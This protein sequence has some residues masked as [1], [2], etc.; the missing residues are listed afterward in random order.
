VEFRVLGALEVVHD[1]K[2]VPLGGRRQ[3][4]LLAILLLRAN[5]VVSN[6]ALIDELWGERPPATAHHTLQAYVSRLRKLL[7]ENGGDENVLVS[8]PSGYLLRI[9]FGA[10]DLD[11]FEH[12][13]E[14]G[15]RALAAGAAAEA[16]EA[17]RAALS[18]WTG[19]ALADLRFEPFARV[20]VERF[21][22]R[23]L[24]V[25]EDRIEA[26]LHR[27]QHV[28]LV[29]ELEALVAEHP[30]RERL[31]EQLMLALY[32][33]GRQ[34]EA[35]EA[36]RSA[37]TYLVEECG[38]EP[39]KQLQTLHQA[40][41]DQDAQLDLDISER[42]AVLTTVRPAEEATQPR[43]EG[44]WPDPPLRDATR[45]ARRLDKSR[46]VTVG[47]AVLAVAVAVGALVV[48]RRGTDRTLRGSAVHPDSVVFIDPAHDK[49]VGQTS[50]GGR[51][52]A[53]AAGF[54]RL[55]VADGANGR[56]LVLDPS[57]FRIED[58][59]PLGREPAALVASGN[60]MWVTDPASGTVSEIAS[61]S[62]TV[63]ATVQVG[64]S[65][66]AIAAGAGALWVADA[67]SG[68]LAR[69]DP[70]TASV[71]DTI[72]V[73]QPLT[74]VTLGLGSVWVTSASSGLLFAIDPHGDRV[75]QAVS[76]GNG[77]SAVRVLGPTVWVANPPDDTLS[78]FDP[79]SGRIRKINASDPAA[80]TV[81]DGALWV[82]DR[83]HAALT[84][85]DPAT[86][87]GVRI[88]TLANPPTAMADVDGKLALITGV[89][90]AEHAGGTLRVVAGDGVDS[91]DPGAAYSATDWQLLSMT[92]DGLLTYAR[93]PQ[94]G[95]GALVPDLATSLPVVTGDGRTFTFTLQ[96][97][98]HYSDGTL[99]RPGDFRR[100]L[101]REYQAGT[102]LAALGVPLAGAQRCG[103]GHSACDL[104]RGVSVDD[105][106]WTVTYH[107]AAPDPAFLYQL[108]LPFGAA[109]P[110]GAP[111]AGPVPA[112][113]P[114]NIASYVPNRTVLLV[115][116]PRF[117]P[118]SAAAQPAGFPEQ[119]SVRLG[120]Q[121]AAQ[122]A[123]VAAGDA[124]IALDTPPAGALERLRRERPQQLH[125]YALGQTD[126]MFLNTRLAPFDRPAVRRA[127]ALAVDRARLVELAGGSQ[128]ARPTCQILPPQFPGYYPY[129][130]STIDPG[131]AGVWH[132]AAQSQARALIAASGTAGMP[133]TV[134]TNAQDPF[135]LA[136]GRYFVDLLDALGYRASLRTY[137][138]EHSYYAHVGLRK[139]RS[140]VG[141]F[142][143]QPDYQAGSAFFAPLFTC[144]AYR[145]DTPYNMNPAGFCDPQLDNQIAHA[146]TLQTV[147]VAAANRAWQAID[148]KITDQAPW[149]PLINPLGIDL[150][151]VRVG[152][153]QRN[154]AFG[155][156]LD[157]LWIQ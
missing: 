151:S 125:P 67:A 78:Q 86:G 20:D 50:I 48:T 112:T 14:E 82:A 113:G 154:P 136:A 24:G 90:P 104:H 132:G 53:I 137:P 96:R 44:G 102:G 134:S 74:D 69:I 4:S 120:L 13:A 23:R 32:R 9:G 38:L 15:R 31:R 95:P 71:V 60:G 97:G 72:S 110:S 7:R 45:R 101:E 43:P 149:I 109:V 119:I 39:G 146:T 139:T 152:N 58:Q 144:D 19:P 8:Y 6:D 127:V 1:G 106:A 5:E 18:L 25:V 138:D 10:F 11:R 157:Q 27:G 22:E 111:A 57:T 21:E 30:L 59:I 12:L 2:S 87:I 49:L 51:P 99:V 34:A 123:A 143:W 65:P 35:L 155:V 98:V 85:L 81:I 36:Y 147:N 122:A 145:P 92:N 56:V 129:C 93:S 66:T 156:L 75:T 61:G 133:V 105:A 26:D 124:D 130:T 80:L 148:A 84:R 54:G 33:S 116:N 115:R 37:R 3:R 107:L 135:K 140:Q 41:L 131:P 108:A 63:V 77:P 70:S 100:A 117:Q 73:G 42:S 91:I 142:G 62:H 150:T 28:A 88:A 114:Y 76:I 153:Y 29:A 83:V 55:W 89:S 46:G 16:A 68:G 126:A 40:I 47:V 17:C 64:T 141:F 94:P 118:W 79:G 103:P 128:L 52:A 121:P